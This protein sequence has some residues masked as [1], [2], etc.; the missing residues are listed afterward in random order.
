[1]SL[2]NTNNT[3]RVISSADDLDEFEHVECYKIADA[4][5]KALSP[6]HQPSHGVMTAFFGEVFGGWSSE[7]MAA[8]VPCVEYIPLVG[9]TGGSIDVSDT[10]DSVG[11][12]ENGM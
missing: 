9:D 10:S 7:I 2:D 3:P 5:I 4:A 11:A 8:A 6:N 1:M 12:V